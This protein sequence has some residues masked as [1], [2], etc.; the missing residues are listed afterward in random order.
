LEV[1]LAAL[2]GITY[3][4]DYTAARAFVDGNSTL[5]PEVR[6]N[7]NNFIAGQ[8]ARYEP[9]AAAAWTMAL[10]A[11]PQR[12]QALIGLGES[13]AGVDPAGAAR[14]AA[15]LPAGES[16]SLALRQA[17]TSWLETDAGQA[18]QWVMDTN[19]HEDYDQAVAAVATQNNF[20]FREP[21]HA[22][23][24]T[25]TIFDDGLRLR[26]TATILAGLYSRDPSMTVAYIR[27][28]TDVTE[29]QRAQLLSQI[30]PK[31]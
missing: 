22:L 12:D 3:N 17:I 7:L 29:E 21:D 23:Q 31:E 26:T 13:W 5:T 16:R 14:F 25:G 15:T 24:W 6:S 10:P 1:N 4:G 20:M 11:G 19:Q 18:R 30:T 2:L 8:W 9:T 28:M 27:G